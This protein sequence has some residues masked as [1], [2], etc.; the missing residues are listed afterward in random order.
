M[1]DEKNEIIKSIDKMKKSIKNHTENRRSDNERYTSDCYE[2][3]FG[4]PSKNVDYKSILLFLLGGTKNIRFPENERDYYLVL[5][6]GIE[7]KPKLT[8]KDACDMSHPIVLDALNGLDIEPNQSLEIIDEVKL[9][10]RDCLSYFQ[11]FESVID[12]NEFSMIGI[13]DFAGKIVGDSKYGT[14]ITHSSKMT[15]P[16]CKFPRIY[17][18]GGKI[19]TDGLIRSG[20]VVIDFDLHIDA[21]KLKV[22]RFLTLPFDK[23]TLF[24]YLK[25]GDFKPLQSIFGINGQ[26][27]EAWY[28]KLKTC[29]TSQDHRT[30]G[31]IKQVWF[32]VE[33]GYHQ[34]SLLQPS[35]LT[36]KLKER[37]DQINS[38]SVDAYLGRKSYKEGKY[39][40]NGFKTVPNITVTKHGGEHP[41][42]ISGL[43]N[44]YQSCYLL[45]SRPPFIEKRDVRFPTK[46]FFIQSVRYYD[47]NDVLERLD[48]VFKI[49]RDGQIPLDNIRKGRDRCLGDF[50]D[51]ILQ[52]MMALR[53]VSN[54]QYS[55]ESSELPAWQKLWLCEQYKEQRLQ[56]DDWLNTLC[57]QI[58]L[59]LANTYKSSIKHPVM[60][61]EAER[62]YIRDYIED[63]KEVL[64]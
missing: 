19:L 37:V 64:R 45:D 53:E 61:G 15:N 2:F 58:S 11:L 57:D 63:N 29:I 5:L 8:F 56:E 24:D 55:P 16:A 47:C 4:N 35:G 28:D 23:S 32:P 34:L 62:Q 60:L 46:N 10:G 42:N 38:R 22:F 43:N 52:K 54:K 12:I 44:K 26:T 27:A 18:D 59:W 7:I 39:Y 6:L 49:E 13:V 50:L 51:V 30:H 20:N 14:V 17:F 40:A 1:A 9:H 21:S 48:K 3:I 33:F 25:R 41:K 31:F 36:F